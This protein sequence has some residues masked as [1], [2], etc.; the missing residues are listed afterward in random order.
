[1]A[2][3]LPLSPYAALS[4]ALFFMPFALIQ[5]RGYTPAAA[6]AAILPFVILISLLSPLAGKIG[7]RIGPRLPL[8]VGPLVAAAGFVLLA[9]GDGGAPYAVSGLPGL[10]VL[11]LGI[12]ARV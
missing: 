6:G 2:T 7:D 8:T 12:A 10:F 11:G 5:A 3:L 4:G 1:A 9:L